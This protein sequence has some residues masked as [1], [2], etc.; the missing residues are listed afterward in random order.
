MSRSGASLADWQDICNGV[1]E[2][3][4]AVMRDTSGNTDGNGVSWSLDLLP[5]P[6]SKNHITHNDASNIVG[7][8]PLNE[9][10]RPFCDPSSPLTFQTWNTQDDTGSAPNGV[11]SLYSGNVSPPEI[12]RYVPQFGS[13]PKAGYYLAGSGWFLDW[14]DDALGYMTKAATRI[15]YPTVKLYRSNLQW[16]PYGTYD[17][18]PGSVWDGVTGDWISGLTISSYADLWTYAV[19]HL[20]EDV[21]NYWDSIWATIGT[22]ETTVEIW[23]ASWEIPHPGVI[24]ANLTLYYSAT[25]QNLGYAPTNYQQSGGP[26]VHGYATV[27]KQ[28]ASAASPLTFGF[29]SSV[30]PSTAPAPGYY[31]QE[32]LDNF[33]A[34][35]DFGPYV[36][37]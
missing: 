33:Y 37:Y 2:R 32:T 27:T 12:C 30:I 28:N 21:T 4:K 19:Q 23:F 34:V 26:Y 35:W 11:N 8:L 7:K 9:L 6:V 24:P 36:Q 13:Y 5:V 14:I 16:E 3:R 1:N 18:P 10:A 15:V 25:G 17:Q 29:T 31:V 22:S 20:H